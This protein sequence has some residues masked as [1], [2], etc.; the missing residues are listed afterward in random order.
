MIK[1]GEFDFVR[2][3]FTCYHL[4]ETQCRLFCCVWAVVR[5]PSLQLNI[6]VMSFWHYILQVS[7]LLRR[8]WNESHAMSASTLWKSAIV[9]VALTIPYGLHLF[10]VCQKR[11]C[12]RWLSCRFLILYKRF[13]VYDLVGSIKTIRI[14][15]LT[16]QISFSD[17]I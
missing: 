2:L 15:T 6:V 8:Y 4:Y 12:P 10:C 7:V 1:D 13:V 17:W 9:G 11:M 14:D 16:V 3:L 5:S